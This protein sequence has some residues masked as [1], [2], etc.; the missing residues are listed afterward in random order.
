MD[1]SRNYLP[2]GVY[3]EESESTL[4]SV[5]GIPPTLVAIVG[6]ATGY[7]VATEQVVLGADAVHLAHQGIDTTSAS[8]TVASTG[9]AVA[10][11]DYTLTKVGTTTDQTYTTD[12]LRASGAEVADGTVVNLTYRYTDPEYFNP[13]RLTNFEDVKDAYGEPLNTTV[14]TPGDTTYQYVTSPLS[15]AAM[16]AFQN[17]A[18]ELVLCAATPPGSGA[19]TDAAKSTARRTA[20]AT[21]YTKVET[22]PAI[23]VIVP[24]TSGIADDDAVGVLGDFSGHLSSTATEGYFR[25]GILGFDPAVDTAP[26]SMLAGSGVAN[27]R[28][29]LAYAG[30]AGLNM[31]SGAG[32]TSF[33]VG[34]SYLAAAYAGRMAALPVQY[35]ITKQP[36]VGFSGLA[37]TPLANSLKNQ[38]SAAGVAVAEVDRIGRLTVRHGVTT[39]TTNVNTRE[40]SVVRA[41]DS[42]VTSLAEGMANSGLIGDPMDSDLLLSVKSAV[43][44]ILE[45]AVAEGVIVSYSGLA[46]RQTSTDPSVVEVKFAYKPAYPL[47]YITISFSI[48]MANGTTDL[49]D[50][51]VAA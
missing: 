44:G 41:R 2:P 36:I 22:D 40:A 17:G 8:V 38:Y 51:D 3:I 50:E 42:M 48:D 12:L 5:T 34:H 1:F 19:T 9:E 18:T 37:G 15:L 31:Y 14:A 7:Q 25:F 28:L 10:S 35:A 32:N 24:I 4:V 33:A 29:M 46:L 6:P 45:N 27:R 43:S 39:L 26:D 30:P 16:I 11:G 23:T 47:N 20:L 13:R 21:A 49:V